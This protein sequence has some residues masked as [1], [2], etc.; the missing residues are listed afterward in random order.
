MVKFEFRSHLLKVILLITSV[1]FVSSCTEDGRKIQKFISRVN[2]GEINA[3][4]K[5]IYP[6]DY[7]KLQ[8]YK[9][10]LNKTPNLYMKMVDKENI[11][12]NGVEAVKVRLEIRNPSQYYLNYMTRMNKLDHT[13]HI[14]DTIY[15][16]ETVKGSKMSFN[17]ASITG[18]N[19]ELATISETSSGQEKKVNIR[20]G[21]GTDYPVLY[22]VK[23]GDKLVIDSYSEDPEW[24]HCFTV[25]DIC[26]TIDGYIIRSAVSSVDPE[27]FPLG[28]FDSLGIVLSVVI[29][30]VVGV[31]PFGLMMIADALTGRGCMGYIIL[32]G[33]ILGLIYIFYQ[34]LENI[35]F[36]LFIINLPY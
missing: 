35:L 28:I 23:S 11:S 21:K 14:V 32:V 15:M 25:D 34:L 18:E 10:I 33:L 3:A 26:N 6:G 16:R 20:S 2:A 22:Q 8:L 7:A 13:G 31:L 12:V 30:L 29:L 17:W 4:S 1:I 19:L 9:E 24:V 5:Y 27:F 36:E